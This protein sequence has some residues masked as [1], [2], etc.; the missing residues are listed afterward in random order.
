M[1]GADTVPPFC[2]MESHCTNREEK[3]QQQSSS[4]FHK[5]TCQTYPNQKLPKTIILSFSQKNVIGS[6]QNN[7]TTNP[8]SSFSNNIEATFFFSVLVYTSIGGKYERKSFSLN[9]IKIMYHSV[10]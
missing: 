8:P 10:V 1:E 9:P 4:T 5:S 2:P 3:Q 7:C 6:S